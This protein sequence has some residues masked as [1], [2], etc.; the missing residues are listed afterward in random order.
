MFNTTH[1]IYFF[2]CNLSFQ[3]PFYGN[4]P[5]LCLIENIDINS[6]KG[7]AD[8]TMSM[9]KKTFDKYMNDRFI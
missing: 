3:I 2:V 5:Y 9:F 8:R 6:Q 4:M 7:R 1:F